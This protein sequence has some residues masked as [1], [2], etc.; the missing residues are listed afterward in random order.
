MEPSRTMR[1]M[2]VVTVLLMLALAANCSTEQGSPFS[3]KFGTS[4]REYLEIVAAL[5]EQYEFKGVPL[6]PPLPGDAPREHQRR[7]IVLVSETL[8]FCQYDSL[9]RVDQCKGENSEY[10]KHVPVNSK[11][12]AEE[13]RLLIDVNSSS[14]AFNCREKT[15]HLCASRSAIEKIFASDGW[16]DDFYR[17]YAG[18]AGLVEIAVPVINPQ[19]DRAVVY[20]SHRCDGLCGEG[21]LFVMERRNGKWFLAN[22]EQLWIS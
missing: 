11:V 2:R 10:L 9:S 14:N 17:E 7:K 4:E 21:L 6:P 15:W 13:R 16:W 18:T 22:R 19:R 1:K 5:T 3:H 12:S 8:R 20:V